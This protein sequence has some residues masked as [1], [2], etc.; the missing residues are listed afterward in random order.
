[1]GEEAEGVGSGLVGFGVGAEEEVGP[2]VEEEGVGRAVRGP[3][4]GTEVMVGVGLGAE[5]LVGRG[6]GAEVLV[7]PGVDEFVGLGVGVTGGDGGVVR[8]FAADTPPIARAATAPTAMA[9]AR[10]EIRIQL[11]P[12]EWIGCLDRRP[13]RRKVGGSAVIH[14]TVRPP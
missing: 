12:R 13:W 7:G 14:A 4:V 9:A 3:G 1:M 11:S 8:V 2:G 6:V 5:E 10:L